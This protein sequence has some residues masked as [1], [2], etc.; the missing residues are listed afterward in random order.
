MTFALK[1][2]FSIKKLKILGP[3]VTKIY[4]NLCKKFCEYPTCLFGSLLTEVW[5]VN[6]V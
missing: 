1:S 2:T 4:R 6:L 5:M 3:K